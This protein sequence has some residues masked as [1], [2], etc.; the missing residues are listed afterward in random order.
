[1]VVGCH[2]GGGSI[3]KAEP[4]GFPDGLDLSGDKKEEVRQPAGF[5]LSGG[6][7]GL[8][9]DYLEVLIP[10]ALLPNPFS[11]RPLPRKLFRHLAQLL[12][13]MEF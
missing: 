12:L 1:M 4:K 9:V 5:G 8:P 11:Y 13:P 2:R 7:V 10:A 3:L 6:R